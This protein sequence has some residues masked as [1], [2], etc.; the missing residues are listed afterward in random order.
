MHT[1]R[2]FSREVTFT[3]IVKWSVLMLRLVGW[4]S[5]LVFLQSTI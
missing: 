3:V 5:T 4:V 1:T 2:D